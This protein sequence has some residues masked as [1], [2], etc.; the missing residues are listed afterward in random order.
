MSIKC[1]VYEIFDTV[2]L[3]PGL[4]SFQVTVNDTIWSG[5]YDFQL[6]FHSDYRPNLHHFRD[7]WWFPSKIANF[8][9]PCI[10]R[11]TVRVTLGIGHQHRGQIKL[12]W[13]GYQT[14]EKVLRSDRINHLGTMTVC[15]GRTN[16]HVAIAILCVVRVRRHSNICQ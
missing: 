2:T 6:T 8:P 14:V 10:L 5:T 16:K 3:K 1:N 12:E 9:I 4:G 7:E 13:W 11:P 15:A